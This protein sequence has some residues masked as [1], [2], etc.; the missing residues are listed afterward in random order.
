MFEPFASSRVHATAI[1]NGGGYDTALAI[2][3]Q[4]RWPFR[5][6]ETRRNVDSIDAGTLLLGM[7]YFD[8]T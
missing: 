2:W 5:I 8:E 7:C 6:E 4:G 3:T 1:R